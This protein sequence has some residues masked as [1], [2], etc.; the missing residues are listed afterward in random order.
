M[1]TYQGPATV[2]SGGTEYP[3]TADLTL[4]TTGGLKEW[5]GTVTAS[6]EAAAWE[7]FNDNEETR[8]SI[9]GREGVFLAGTFDADS[10][11]LRVQGSGPA[12]FGD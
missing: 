1:T 11:E 3:V 10:A 6:G 8:L 4:F 12:P 7:I 2:T 9:D 5:N